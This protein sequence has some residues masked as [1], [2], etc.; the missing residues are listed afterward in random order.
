MLGEDT[1]LRTP[2]GPRTVGSLA[3]TDVIY[4]DDNQ[5]VE[6]VVSPPLQ[7]DSPSRISFYPWPQ[8]GA[9]AVGARLLSY[10]VSQDHALHLIASN[11]VNP[12]LTD[13]PNGKPR[14]VWTTRCQPY[15]DLAQQV[16]QELSSPMVSPPSSPTPGAP[17]RMPTRTAR[18]QTTVDPATSS[19]PESDRSF[20]PSQALSDPS[21]E[22][23]SEPMHNHPLTPHESLEKAHRKFRRDLCLCRSIRRTGFLCSTMEEAEHVKE[24]LR[25]LR[26]GPTMD[27]NI[28]QAYDVV[29]I[30]AQEWHEAQH[31]TLRPGGWITNLKMTRYSYQM[32]PAG[33]DRDDHLPVDPY[34]V[35]LW[36]GD[37][38][39]R[40]PTI[41]VSERDTQIIER[42]HRL[43]NRLND[44][45]PG[46]AAPLQVKFR[47]KKFQEDSIIKENF[48]VWDCAITSTAFNRDRRW[49][50]PIVTG[51]RQLGVYAMHKT[52]GVPDQYLNGSERTRA[53]VLA[54][55][56]D[57]DGSWHGSGYIF[58][59]SD[60]HLPVVNSFRSLALGLGIRAHEVVHYMSPA[61]GNKNRLLP[62][63]RI[64]IGGPNIHKLQPFLA[65]PRKKQPPPRRQNDCDLRTI[66]VEQV[67]QHSPPLLGRAIRAR[68]PADIRGMLVRRQVIRGQLE[69]GSIVVV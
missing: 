24:M 63:C 22:L 12:M 7:M 17:R 25:D 32:L 57:S 1:I 49:W 42:L 64:T 66:K 43:C 55:L 28:V 6:V 44:S 23:S 61:P 26:V 13:N 5:E 30:T 69:D 36:F 8:S 51:L 15:Q 54:G 67:D 56:I 14:V 62:Q 39:H 59:Q 29:S 9:R 40:T 3:T 38:G 52:T 27:T 47:R 11:D 21:Q 68:A 41:T 19:D 31:Q 46:W 48:Q 50:N 58:S 20:H 35:G 60:A 34:F 45:R 53:S 33:D 2:S 10:T 65:L 18:S 37:G 4:D 16:G